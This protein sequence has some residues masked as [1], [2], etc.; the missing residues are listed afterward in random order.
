VLHETV[1]CLLNIPNVGLCVMMLLFDF[2]GVGSVEKWT[3]G[4]RECFD[5]TVDDLGGLG[6]DFGAKRCNLFIEVALA[7]H[8]VCELLVRTRLAGGYSVRDQFL[9][10][11]CVNAVGS[12][13][14]GGGSIPI[15]TIAERT[16]GDAAAVSLS[17]IV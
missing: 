14:V 17:R 11:V 15:A 2:H 13:L 4:S 12:C 9:Y 7:F 3:I 1:Q 5:G 8:D 10:G 16:C 6:G